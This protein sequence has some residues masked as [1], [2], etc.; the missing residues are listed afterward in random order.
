M[1]GFKLLL[2]EKEISDSTGELGT[3]SGDSLVLS[4]GSRGGNGATQPVTV[5]EELDHCSADC[6]DFLGSFQQSKDIRIF[7]C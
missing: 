1:F 6:R 7:Y 2:F 4:S 3:T 5:S